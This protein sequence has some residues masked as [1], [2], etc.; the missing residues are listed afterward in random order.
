MNRQY[1]LSLGPSKEN[2]KT[3]HEALVEGGRRANISRRPIEITDLD[4]GGVI[5]GTVWPDLRFDRG[6]EVPLVVREHL[7]GRYPPLFAGCDFNL[8]LI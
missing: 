6:I 4:N 7:V 8:S 1:P 3:I 5:I 2:P